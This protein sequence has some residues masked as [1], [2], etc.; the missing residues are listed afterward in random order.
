MQKKKR[1]GGRFSSCARQSWPSNNTTGSVEKFMHPASQPAEL[2]AQY[3]DRVSYTD[4]FKWLHRRYRSAGAHY[5]PRDKRGEVFWNIYQD[6]Y[7]SERQG[8]KFCQE[9]RIVT[10]EAVQWWTWWAPTVPLSSSTL[11]QASKAKLCSADT[12]L[13]YATKRSR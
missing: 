12:Q 2:C 6:S 13:L 5:S 9:S 7:D 11:E 3:T 4:K 10:R 1:V 8:P